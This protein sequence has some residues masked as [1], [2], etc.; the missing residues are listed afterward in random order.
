METVLLE[1]V[2]IT[3]RFLLN[4]EKMRP[5]GMT[6]SI[7]DRDKLQIGSCVLKNSFDAPCR[8]VSI[9]LICVIYVKVLTLDTKMGRS[10]V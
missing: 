4:T 5:K 8:L 10:F 2:N 1:V 6:K 3:K 9:G 7:D